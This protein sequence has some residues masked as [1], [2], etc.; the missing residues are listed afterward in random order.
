MRY[1][2]VTLIEAVLF[3]SIAV[4]LIIGGLVF[5]RQA[6]LSSRVQTTLRTY[7]ALIAGTKE[8]MMFQPPVAGQELND[9]LIAAD[10]VPANALAPGVAGGIQTPWGTPI[11]MRVW[12][13]GPSTGFNMIAR[14]PSDACS[15]LAPFDGTSGTGIMGA[16]IG[17]VCMTDPVASPSDLNGA[18]CG[19]GPK[20]DAAWGSANGAAESRQGLTPSEAGT[21]CN[22][23]GDQVYMVAAFEFD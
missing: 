21:Y 3:I 5:F 1:R 13:V 7:T 8:L 10:A 4:G 12:Q 11:S 20:R 23:F 14:V 9:I 6:Q 17:Y 16:H 18:Y 2:G 19:Y 15:R 22:M